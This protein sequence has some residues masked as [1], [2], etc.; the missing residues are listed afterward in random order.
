M[1]AKMK[2]R[3][4]HKVATAQI[5]FALCSFVISA[6]TL[7]GYAIDYRPLFAPI[8]SI[9]SHQIEI[10]S[11]APTTAIA[12]I[13]LSIAVIIDGLRTQGDG[14]QSKVNGE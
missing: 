5:S 12:I 13:L 14:Q 11:M 9:L 7:A 6:G 8:D 10:P 4:L 1:A 3:T 2:K